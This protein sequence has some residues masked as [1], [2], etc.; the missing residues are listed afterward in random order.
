MKRLM[1]MS[2]CLGSMVACATTSQSV[3]ASEPSTPRTSGLVMEYFDHSVR[4]QDDLYR[5]AKRV[6][7]EY[8]HV[9]L[10]PRSQ[11]KVRAA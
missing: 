8:P 9:P 3:P 6:N 10:P 7:F 1:A 11:S 4:P 5:F 2:F